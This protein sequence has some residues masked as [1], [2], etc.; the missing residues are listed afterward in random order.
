MTDD[1]LYKQTNYF[2]GRDIIYYWVVVHHSKLVL[3]PLNKSEFD[4]AILKFNVPMTLDRHTY[5]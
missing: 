2:N 4:E 3:G 5:E 1:P